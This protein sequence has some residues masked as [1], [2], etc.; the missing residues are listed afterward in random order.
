MKGEW[1]GS[2][3]YITS[4][5]GG[6]GTPA[7]TVVSETTSGQSPS[8]GTSTNYAR[9]DHTH[10]TPVG[11]GGISGQAT[12]NFGA[13]TQEDS[14]ARVTVS[15]SSVSSSS[16]ITVTPSGAATSNHDPDDYACEEVSG[17]AT[18]IVDGVSFDI[19]GV[20]PNGA[21]GSYQF[22]YVIN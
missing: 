21:Y 16:I 13:N 6:T 19:V 9:E 10:G 14:I 15:T 17:H 11:G 5:A 1:V 20:A 22:N 8:V 18:N 7:T 3:K 4:Q 2:K 12:V